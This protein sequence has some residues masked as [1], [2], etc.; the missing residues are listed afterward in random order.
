MHSIQSLVPLKD[1]FDVIGK[2]EFGQEW[3][4]G[5]A[6]AI[7][8]GQKSLSALDVHARGQRTRRLMLDAIESERL[9]IIVYDGTRR[10]RYGATA[11]PQ[12]TNVYPF[13]TQEPDL[14][15]VEL[16]YQ[17]ICYALADISRLPKPKQQA[18]AKPGPKGRY[19]SFTAAAL[20][21]LHE[22]GPSQTNAAVIAGVAAK[23]VPADQVPKRT[24]ARVIINRLRQQVLDDWT[25]VSNSG[26]T[27][28]GIV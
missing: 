7:R 8:L 10:F 21:C 12:I 14:G 19:A 3:T 6:A 17:D 24:Q 1:A 9:G 11:S 25:A 15:S 20:N 26:Q 23:G 22:Y 5:E 18:R 28:T 4:G 13:Q 2:L 16:A 27:A